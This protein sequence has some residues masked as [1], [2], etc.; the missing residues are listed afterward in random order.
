MTHL[1]MLSQHLYSPDMQ[2]RKRDCQPGPGNGHIE[3]HM[4]GITFL[5]RCNIT[6]V[7]TLLGKDALLVMMCYGKGRLYSLQ[8]ILI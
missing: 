6:P 2:D 1:R 5:K 8:K 3:K 7:F 4:G